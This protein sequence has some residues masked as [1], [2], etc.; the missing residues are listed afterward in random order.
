[1][2][3]KQT[4]KRTTL[5]GYE[6]NRPEIIRDFGRRG[7]ETKEQPFLDAKGINLQQ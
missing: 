7:A 3:K 5:L 4:N 1:L 2:V 6:R